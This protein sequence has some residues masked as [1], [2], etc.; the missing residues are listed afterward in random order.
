VRTHRK[1]RHQHPLIWMGLA[2]AVLIAL[3]V[4]PR[5]W[6]LL[7]LAGAGFVAYRVSGHHSVQPTR[8]PK[9]LQGQVVTETCVHGVPDPCGI[10]DGASS[11]VDHGEFARRVPT[12]KSCGRRSASCPT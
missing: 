5:L 9:V 11:A 7:L 12:T 1:L 8:P 3:Q 4:V 2:L 10:C 6:P